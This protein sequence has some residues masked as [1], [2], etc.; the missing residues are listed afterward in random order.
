M[1]QHEPSIRE[2]AEARESELGTF[3]Y[4]LP[5]GW[6]NEM[7]D[8]IGEWPHGFVWSYSAPSTIFGRPFP[9]T[10]AATDQLA[11]LTAARS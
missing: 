1:D 10:A 5:V 7:H 6:C 4:A 3:D 2:L 11:R 9:L 8:L